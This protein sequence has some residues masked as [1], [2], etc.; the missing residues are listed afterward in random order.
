MKISIYQ[1][2]NIHE[3]GQ[4]E[5]QEDSIFPASGQ[6]DAGER[7]YMVCD[8]MGGHESGEVASAAVCGALS[9]YFTSKVPAEDS[10]STDTFNAALAYA[11]DALDRKDNG[12]TLKKM[13]TTL[14]MVM[15]H[16]GGAL[17][18]HIGDSRIYQIR[19]AEKR[20]IY[21]SRDH[22]LVNDLYAIGEITKE[23]MKTAPNRNVITRAM[24][25]CM[26]RRDTAEVAQITDIE[27]GDYFYICSDGMLEKMEDEEIV[28]IFS[29]EKLTDEQKRDA[30]IEATVNNKDN[31]SAQII[32]I[33]SV[34]QE[35]EDAEVISCDSDK[36]PA[37]NSAADESSTK[38]EPK[39]RSFLKRLFGI[40][41]IVAVLMMGYTLQAKNMNVVHSTSGKPKTETKKTDTKPAKK[42]TG[43]KTTKKTG[44]KVKNN[45]KRTERQEETYTPVQPVHHVTPAER[46]MQ[47][48]AMVHVAGGTFTM[49]ST[50]S[51]ADDDEKP[52]HSVSVG[53]Y[54]IGK[55]EVTQTQWTSIMGSNPSY[56]K[57]DNR[58]VE[59]VSWTD[60]CRFCNA[61]SDH[62][63][64]QRCYSISGSGDD[65]TVTMVRSSGGFRLPTEAEWEFAARGGNSSGGYKYSG[66]DNI[67]NVA[68]YTDNSGNATHDVGGKNSNEIGI[69]DMS[70]NVYEWCWDWYGAYTSQ[71]QTNPTGAYSGSYRVRRGGSWSR[72]AQCCRCAYRRRNSP[73]YRDSYLGLRLVLAL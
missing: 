27:A 36:E 19:P 59:M 54:Y 57:G 37:E 34:E 65:V 42:V 46:A 73:S 32:R 44:G 1:P 53:G 64:L 16:R 14:A 12:K 20:I 31:H 25:P 8:G 49:G 33:K 70:G 50:G 21:V 38:V 30:L 61:L 66:S 2:L 39:H 43:N 11:Y 62:Y 45:R 6:S 68:W 40:G 67:G 3:L 26:E 9:E 52:L 15:L 47:D 18:A 69:Y 29:D 58:P 48:I 17:A 63:G 35:E 7:L 22:S 10:V 28:G 23:Q 72:Y 13:G 51:D 5:N 71:A 60:C 55:Y 4:R 41:I 56:F 24:Q